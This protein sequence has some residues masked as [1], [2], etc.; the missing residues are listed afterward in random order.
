VVATTAH[1]ITEA[2]SVLISSI[3][4]S[5]RMRRTDEE[6][7]REIA[8]SIKGVGL[9]HSITIAKREDHYVL[10]AGLHRLESF[11]LLGLKAIPANIIEA[12]EL[13]EDLIQCEENLCRSPLNAIYTSRFLRRR[14]ELLISLGRKA[15]VGNNQY[16]EEKLTN[17]ELASQYGITPRAYQYKKAIADMNEE[18]ADI[19]CETKFADNM[20]DMYK[21]QKEPDKI[22]LEV[23]NLLASG[24]AKTFR[25]AWVLGHMKHKEERWS[26]EVKEV[27]EE[28]GI[29]KSIMKWERKKDKLNDLCYYVSHSEDARKVKVTG[30]FGTNEIANYS[31]LPEQSRWFIKFFSK[32]G[33]LIL[34]NFAGKGSNLIAAALEGRRVV[35]Y[36]LSKTNLALIKEACLEHTSIKAEDL[37]L[38]RSCGVELA[39]YEGQKEIFDMCL[40]DP[41]Y[42]GAEDYG[43][44]DERDLCRIKSIDQ[45]NQRMEVCISNLS[46]LIKRSNFKKKVFHPIVIKIGSVR[47]SDAGLCDLATEIE[48]IARKF[49]LVLHD[50][51]FN[52]LRSAYQSY[53]IARCIENKYTVKSHETNLVFV[54][55]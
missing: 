51:I 48:I 4:V 41:P 5:H 38:H 33:D 37:T 44:D 7:V 18:A 39:E 20:M 9:L 40:L 10:V 36:D 54:R 34:D 22:Q 50:K 3:K 25:R 26:D 14:E 32:E 16:T 53:N 11:K 29:P 35:G 23:A 49:S 43:N 12:N 46:R 17:K 6:K 21:L 47:R 8:E 31:M 28:L 19:L 45:Y 2:T 42:L 55:Y 13:I 52:E 24:K 1:D 30:Q 15:V 27:K